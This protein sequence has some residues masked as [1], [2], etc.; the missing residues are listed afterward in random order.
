[1]NKF[2]FGAI[3]NGRLW[4][5]ELCVSA[6]YAFAIGYKDVTKIL[7]ETAHKF[8]GMIRKHPFNKVKISIW[9]AQGVPQ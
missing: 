9:N 6:Q 1:M 2:C 8:H 7:I 5:K 4:E 3:Y